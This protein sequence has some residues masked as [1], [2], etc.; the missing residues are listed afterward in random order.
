MRLY[1][2]SIIGYQ[3]LLWHQKKD[4]AYKTWK[5]GVRLHGVSSWVGYYKLVVK[6]FNGFSLESIEQRN[7]FNIK[8]D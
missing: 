8:G 1:V 6:I 3:I 2:Q 5:T 4:G 7:Q